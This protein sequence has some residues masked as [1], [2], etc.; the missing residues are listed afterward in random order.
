MLPLLLWGFKEEKYVLRGATL[1]LAARGW[2]AGASGALL[3]QSGTGNTGRLAGD[4][5]SNTAL[6]QIWLPT[7]I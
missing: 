7:G 5:A 6:K 1:V 4:H 3:L 2:Y